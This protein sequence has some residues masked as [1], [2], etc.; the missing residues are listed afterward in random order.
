MENNRERYRL[1]KDKLFFVTI[2]IYFSIGLVLIPVYQ[3]HINPDGVSY[4]SIA[5]KYSRG[6]LQDAINGYWGPLYIWVMSLFI[7]LGI[8]S[9]VAAKLV[10]LLFG[11]ATLIAT[12]LLSYRF[13]INQTIRNVFFVAT[14][15]ALLFFSFAFITAD[16]VLLT[17]LLFYFYLVFDEHYS[18]KRYRGARMR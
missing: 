8:D 5:E 11:S 15:P 6:D 9:L 1:Y 7:R 18:Q 13:D 2:A 16:L 10:L 4:I 17:T 12:R 14:V 3:Y